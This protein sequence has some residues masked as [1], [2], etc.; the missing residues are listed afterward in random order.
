MCVVFL[1]V[2]VI[3]ITGGCIL[4]QSEQ[5]APHASQSEERIV[6]G[7]SRD[8]SEEGA[9]KKT[10]NENID[11]TAKICELAHAAGVSCEGEIGFVGYSGGERSSGTDPEEASKFAKDL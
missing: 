4:L 2:F 11:E 6:S 9:G 3:L 5:R 7:L 8:A 10:L 1:G